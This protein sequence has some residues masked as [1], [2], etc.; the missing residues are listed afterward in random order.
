M[1]VFPPKWPFNKGEDSTNRLLG[2]V[3]GNHDRLIKVTA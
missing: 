2:S 3:K 1:S